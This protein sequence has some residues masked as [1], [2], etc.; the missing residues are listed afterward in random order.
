LAS[1]QKGILTVI[2]GLIP[3]AETFGLSAEMR[4]ATSGHAFWQCAFSHW[5]KVPENIAAEVI[6]HIRERKGLP[7]ETPT[8]DMFIDEE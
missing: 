8:S 5:E 6:R 4:S 3:V 1:E 7:P 2:D